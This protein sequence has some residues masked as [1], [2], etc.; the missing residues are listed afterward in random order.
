MMYRKALLFNDFAMAN[1]ILRTPSL[2]PSQHRLMGR[3]LKNYHARTWEAERL[4]VAITGNM[5]KFMQN[6]SLRSF[7]LA[8][9]DSILAEASPC[10]RIWGIGFEE[11][12]AVAN[13]QKWGDNMLGS[14]L[15][16]V[17]D[18]IANRDSWG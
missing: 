7:L 1:L 5:Y 16:T 14:V 4:D 3:R 2:H 13:V 10:D 12:D 8:T 17:R 15:M 9:G 18:E 11:K 6:D